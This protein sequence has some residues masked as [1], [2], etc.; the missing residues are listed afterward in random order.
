MDVREVDRVA[1]VFA[2]GGGL[3]AGQAGML[4]ALAEAGIRPDLV[5]G[6]SA[7]ALN[8][9]AYATDPTPAGLE[10]METMWLS[11]RR[12]TVLPLSVARLAAALAG[13]GDG[14]VSTAALRALIEHDLVAPRLTDTAIP[15]HVVVT[16]LATGHPAV[17]S[18]ETA[19]TALL[20]SSAFPGVFPP[21]PIDGRLYI[22]GGVAA[23]TPVLQAE[24]LGATTSYILPAA[25]PTVTGPGVPHGAAPLAFHALNHLLHHAARADIAAARGR[26]HVLPA[27]PATN[28]NPLAFHETSRLI[29]AGYNLT[30][31][32]LRRQEAQL[33]TATS[34][35]APVA[36]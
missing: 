23:D 17:L 36:A 21:V 26:I 8:A 34:A 14:L 19:V 9:V 6:S 18:D 30:R 1:F 25:A 35:N 22:D 5:I 15:A 7:G 16:D 29:E 32:W 33:I 27:P 3:A 11:V 20:A 28:P 24:A 12:R 31:T 4:R 10:R 2:G 13:R